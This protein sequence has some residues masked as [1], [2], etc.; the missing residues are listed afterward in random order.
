MEKLIQGLRRFQNEVFPAKQELFERLA[1]GQQPSTLFITC[2]DSRVVPDLFT[3][4]EPGELFVI[5]NAGNIVPPYRLPSGGVTATI[6]FAVVAL[7]VRHIV[8][9]GHADCGA[10]K[11]LLHPERLASMPTVASWLQQAEAARRIVAD[12]YPNLD[13][14]AA[15]DTL[16]RENVLAQLQNLHTHPAVASGLAAGSLQLYGWVYDIRTGQVDAYDAARQ[17]FVRLDGS[18]APS[19]TPPP[20][21]SRATHTG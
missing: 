5:R 10:M 18:S 13:E 16:I 19:A 8:V 3:Q 6:E 12:N 4:A 9:C 14:P 17:T 20:G 7:R 15:V 1:K 2:A 21:L 11:G